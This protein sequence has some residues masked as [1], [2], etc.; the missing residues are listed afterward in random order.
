MT[1]DEVTWQPGMTLEM[2][3]RLVIL[4]ALKFFRGNKSQTAQGL[5]ITVKTLGSKLDQ[6]LAADKAREEK[7]KIAADKAIEKQGIQKALQDGRNDQL[8]RW[9]EREEKLNERRL[10]EKR[11][12]QELQRKATSIESNDKHDDSTEEGLHLESAVEAGKK[13]SVPVPERQEVQAMSSRTAAK[14]NQRRNS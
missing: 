8:K 6:Y 9:N 3:E 12:Q 5:G 14:N 4:K 2:I 7:D 11:K 1:N 13:H 10:D